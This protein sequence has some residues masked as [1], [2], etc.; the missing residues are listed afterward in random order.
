MTRRPLAFGVGVLALAVPVFLAGCA[1]AVDDP[2][3]SD[4]VLRVDS[5]NPS[6]LE[7]VSTSASDDI[8]TATISAISRGDA[9]GSTLNDVVIDNY[10]VFYNPPLNGTITALNFASTLV[11][12]GGSS[13]TLSAIAV[14][15]GVKP[16]TP[17]VYNATLQVEGRDVLGNPSS[18]SARFTILAQ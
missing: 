10:T 4:T 9:G 15:A 2:G 13:A 18:A 1:S 8:V 17:G 3:Q 14:P 5:I 16:L 11:V 7:A 12:K 6:Q